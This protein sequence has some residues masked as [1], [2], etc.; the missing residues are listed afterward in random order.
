MKNHKWLQED[1]GMKRFTALIASAALVLSG[2][3]SNVVTPDMDALD[4][5]TAPAITEIDPANVN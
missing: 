2:Y 3:F 4:T 1:M 5:W